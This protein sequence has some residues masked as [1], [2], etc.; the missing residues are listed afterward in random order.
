MYS[1]EMKKQMFSGLSE[2]KCSEVQC[3]PDC[4][5]F[6]AELEYRSLFVC[7][8]SSLSFFFFFL[9]ISLLM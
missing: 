5:T 1:R 8:F 2:V 3:D 7:F 6:S 4:I 9:F